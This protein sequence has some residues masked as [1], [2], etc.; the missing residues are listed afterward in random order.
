MAINKP[1]FLVPGALCKIQ[2]WYGEI[3]DVA[4]SDQRIMV[5]VASPK[6]VWRNHAAEWLQFDP[7]QIQPAVLSEALADARLHIDRITR[8][9]NDAWAMHNAW[10]MK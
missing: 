4:I 7:E 2:H 8:N 5:L 9:L 1:D 3:L 10:A 6:G